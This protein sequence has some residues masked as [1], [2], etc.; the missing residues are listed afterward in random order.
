[1]D[2]YKHWEGYSTIPNDGKVIDYSTYIKKIDDF[3]DEEN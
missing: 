3:T 2:K 1:M